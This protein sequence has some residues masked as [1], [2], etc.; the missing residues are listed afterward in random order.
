MNS[1]VSTAMLLAVHK[2]LYQ[3][4]PI[5]LRPLAFANLRPYL[6]PPVASN[7]LGCYISMLR[8]T[9]FCDKNAG[10][11]ET[12]KQFQVILSH[13]SKRSEKFIAM[14]MSAHLIEAATHFQSFRI[15]TTAVSYPGPLDLQ[16][17][18]GDIRITDEYSLKELEER[19]QRRGAYDLCTNNFQ[20]DLWLAV[21]DQLDQHLS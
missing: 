7:Y 20:K 21:A 8:H 14:L 10:F 18:Y 9:I 15:G 3:N 4:Q 13:S 6:D 11:W 19:S 2:H 16:P 5:P 17:A 12:T 1:V